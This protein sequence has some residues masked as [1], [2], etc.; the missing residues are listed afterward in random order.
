MAIAIQCVV[1]V[2]IGGVVMLV[3]RADWL[4]PC[5]VR[6]ACGI[7]CRKARLPAANVT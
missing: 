2:N 4:S 6:E 1:V 5:C 7:C 3:E